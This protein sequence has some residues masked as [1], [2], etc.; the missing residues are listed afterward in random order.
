MLQLL[1]SPGVPKIDVFREAAYVFN[2]KEL[3]ENF[4]VM[5]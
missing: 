1:K 4:M 3:R 5:L 2:A